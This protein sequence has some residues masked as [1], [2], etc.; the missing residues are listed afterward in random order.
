VPAGTHELV[1]LSGAGPGWIGIDRVH[2]GRRLS[3]AV[4]RGI[5]ADAEI[6]GLGRGDLV[7]WGPSG[8]RLVFARNGHP[9]DRGCAPVRINLVTGRNT[10]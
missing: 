10:R 4:V 7:A 8:T 3:A 6:E 9:E 5:E 1:D 2:D